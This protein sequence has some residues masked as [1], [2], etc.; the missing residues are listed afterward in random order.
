MN[1]IRW[2]LISITIL[3]VAALTFT[4]DNWAGAFKDNFFYNNDYLS[5]AMVIVFIFA[6]TG[7]FKWLLKEEIALTNPNRRRRRR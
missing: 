3:I 4:F 7:I 5:Y 2:I 6:V 1:T